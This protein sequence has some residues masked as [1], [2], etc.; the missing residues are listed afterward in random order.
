[1]NNIKYC[2]KIYNDYLYE[3]LDAILERES[4]ILTA[5]N[6]FFIEFYAIERDSLNAITLEDIQHIEKRIKDN[7]DYQDSIVLELKPKV[8]KAF[9]RRRTEAEKISK[10]DYS[11]LCINAIESK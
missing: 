7:L 8:D 11:R 4:T 3:I 9:W 6:D 5:Q 1:M 10:I 2:N